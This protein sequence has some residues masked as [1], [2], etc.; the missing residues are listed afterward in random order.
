[1]R[2]SREKEAPGTSPASFQLHQQGQVLLL[3]PPLSFLP[4]PRKLGVVGSSRR[5]GWVN[6]GDAHL[7]FLLLWV[8]EPEP[9]PSGGGWRSFQP[10]EYLKF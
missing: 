6:G 7:P 8:G 2:A 5:A 9:A 4:L 1:M 10:K 3:S